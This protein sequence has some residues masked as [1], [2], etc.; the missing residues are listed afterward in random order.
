MK[1]RF[2]IKSR[3]EKMQPVVTPETYIEATWDEHDEDHI[4]IIDKIM[5][6][7]RLTHMEMETLK[8]ILIINYEYRETE[9]ENMNDDEV[10]E[11]FKTIYRL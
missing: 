8:E 5:I 10:I 7:Q 4:D 1:H 11:T 2:G 6:E 9:V 3:N